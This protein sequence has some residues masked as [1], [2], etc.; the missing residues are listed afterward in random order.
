MKYMVHTCPKRLW[1]VNDFLVPDM[2]RQGISKEDIVIWNDK[3]TEGNL[4]A[5]VKSCEDIKKNYPVDDGFWHLQDDVVLSDDFAEKSVEVAKMD[6]I[7]NAFCSRRSNPKKY[8]SI[9][10]RL[11]KR[12]WFSFPCM[13]IPNRYIHSFLRWYYE[14]AVNE[15]PYKSVVEQNKGDDYLFWVSVKVWHRT[16]YIYNLAPNLADHID[17]LLGGS[18]CNGQRGG[19]ARAEYFEDQSKVEQL[20]KD[21]EEYK[22]KKKTQTAA[23]TAR[24]PRKPSETKKTS[25]STTGTKKPRKTQNSEV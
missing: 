12:Y 19:F 20:A 8:A 16:D 1:Y 11:P 21:I 15:E 6:M 24:K 5:W 4:T 10:K 13:Y 23:R 3:K 22:A 18:V 9:G 25:N 14:D 2:M 7:V 17:F